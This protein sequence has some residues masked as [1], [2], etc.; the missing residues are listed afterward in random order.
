[1]SGALVLLGVATLLALLL[2]VPDARRS[3]AEPQAR[4]PRLGSVG[5]PALLAAAGVGL[6]AAEPRGARLGILLL[7]AL[8]TLPLIRRLIRQH[9][10]RRERARRRRWVLE[11]CDALAAE[12]HGGLPTTTALQHACEPFSDLAPVAVAGRLEGDVAGTLRALADTPGGSGLSAVATAWD[13]ASRSGAA[14]AV[15]VERVA[16][17]LRHEADAAAEVAAALGPPRATA[18]MLLV[19]PLFGVALGMAMGANPLAFLLS[20]TVGLG[21]LALGLTLAMLGVL[22]VERLT[23]AAEE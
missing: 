7:G 6:W 20:T 14:L 5:V 3:M 19:L 1:M 11:F 9:Q 21:C 4:S 23:E 16:Q 17:S 15:V 8:V 10:R 12:L 22:W 18:R 13:V 2:A